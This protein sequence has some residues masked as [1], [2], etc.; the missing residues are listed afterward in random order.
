[1]KTCSK[2]FV[3]QPL[4]NFYKHSG[5]RTS[6]GYLNP[7]CKKCLNSISKEWAK[8]N[9]DKVKLIRQR[10]K[11]K[12]KYKLTVEEYETMASKQDFKCYL[13]LK[14]SNQNRVLN[15]DHCHV[16]G[17]VRKLLCDSCNLALG[18]IKDDVLLLENMIKYLKEH[19]N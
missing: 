18:L 1:M 6:A 11:L 4:D 10:T 15:V 5:A 8:A 12:H 16:T 17:L 14:E 19:S 7:K 2:C 9:K 3:E 13:C